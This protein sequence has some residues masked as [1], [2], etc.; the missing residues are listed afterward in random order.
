M[1]S[2]LAIALRNLR[3]H[4]LRTLLSISAIIIAVIIGIFYRSILIAYSESTFENFIQLES[5]HVRLVDEEYAR[6]ERVL[7]LQN[8]VDGFAGE[9]LEAMMATLKAEEAITG[10]LPRLRFPAFYTEG[11]EMEHMLGW[12]VDIEGEVEEIDF[13]RHLAEG[14]LPESGNREIAFGHS[15]LD[16]LNRQVGDRITLL[17]NTSY[18]SLQGS[19]FTITGKIDTGLP[20][21]DA[22]I[23]VTPLDQ[24]QD[25]LDMPDQATELLLFGSN[26]DQDSSIV[27]AVSSKLETDGDSGRYQLTSWRDSG[28]IVQWLMA[29]QR[30]IFVVMA[31]I[32]FLASLIIINTLMMVIKERKKE[33]GTMASLGLKDKEIVMLFTCEGALMGILGSV[34]GAIIGG[35]LTAYFSVVG[36]DFTEVMGSMGD[37]TLIDAVVFPTFSLENLLVAMVLGIIVSTIACIIPAR[38]AAKVEPSEAMRD[39]K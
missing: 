19:T 2:I 37:S 21:F 35:G 13:G 30:I 26:R 16:E 9:G 31:G 34:I 14:R 22:N 25:I 18:N 29:Y 24:A 15:L 28:G 4:K 39:L 38:Q 10:I 11:D 20:Y 6:R 23:F 8:T 3:R 17:Y 32:V 36:L 7:S 12:G 1:R 5:G 33:I 27:S